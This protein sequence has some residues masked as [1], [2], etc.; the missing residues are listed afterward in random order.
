M[1]QS[2]LMIEVINRLK[3][4]IIKTPMAGYDKA[5]MGRDVEI[6]LAMAKEFD[7]SSEEFIKSI[8]GE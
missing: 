5:L 8:T 1:N 6:V 4:R 3:A 2:K 7:K